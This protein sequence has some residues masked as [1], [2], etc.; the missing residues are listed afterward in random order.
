M[1]AI[2]FKSWCETKGDRGKQLLS[3]WTG[4]CSK[5]E[6]KADEVDI[7]NNDEYT[8]KCSNNHY[9][10]AKLANR[11]K[12]G[13]FVSTECPYCLRRQLTSQDWMHRGDPRDR[14]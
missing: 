7:D 3:E 5:G 10:S 14:L 11:V 2:S 9:F 13:D 8:W 6:L 12:K 4:K 1:S